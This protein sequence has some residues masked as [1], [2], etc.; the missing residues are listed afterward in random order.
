MSKIKI[1]GHSNLIKDP[2]TGAILSTKT[3]EYE[4]YIQMRNAKEQ[5]SRKL[6]YLYKEVLNLKKDIQHIKSFLGI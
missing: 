6:D 5:E 1:E 3:N 2:D 4:Q